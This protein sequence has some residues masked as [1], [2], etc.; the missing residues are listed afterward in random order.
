[1]IKLGTLFPEYEV[2]RKAGRATGTLGISLD[3]LDRF[4][5][6]TL[7]SH[8]FAERHTLPLTELCKRHAFERRTVKEQILTGSGI[9]KSEPF[10]SQ[11]LDC[12]FC[13]LNCSWTL[14]AA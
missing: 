8:A 14:D 10:V 4:R 2:E 11:P 7:W 6:R 12:A 5:P 1:M 3:Q 9:D 13:H